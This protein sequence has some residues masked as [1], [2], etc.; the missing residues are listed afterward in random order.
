MFILDTNVISE[1][2]IGKLN[3]SQAVIDWSKTQPTSRL[4]LSVVTIFELERGVLL[5]ERKTPSEGANLRKWLEE[6]KLNFADR[7]LSYASETAAICAALH[8]P[9]P[10]PERDAMIA[11]SALE[12]KFTVVTRNVADFANTGVE[13]VNPWQT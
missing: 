7:V 5:L 1:L 12:H 2:R 6:I 11:A 3:A 10:Q 4:F 9:N 13:L 8:V